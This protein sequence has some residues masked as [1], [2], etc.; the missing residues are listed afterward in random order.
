M[1]EI[2]LSILGTFFTELSS[3]IGK[4]AV[5][6]KLESVYAMGFLDSIWGAGF[7]LIAILFNVSRGTPLSIASWPTFFLRVF[8]EIFQAF[9]AVEALARADRSTLGFLK[10]GTI[11]LLL[12]QFYIFLVLLLFFYLVSHFI[13][14]E[15]PLRLLKQPLL[16]FQ[17]MGQGLGGV[18][19]SFAYPFAPASVILAAARSSGVFWSV[20]AGSSYFH[21]KH[22]LVK[23]I[24]LLACIA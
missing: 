19:G 20:I 16:S 18:F 2:L 6:K 14:K 12:E 4:S 17:A 15:R 13:K 1:F 8:L 9:L 3:S 5:A 7:F 21:E 22:V 23:V 10:T 24:A 11:P